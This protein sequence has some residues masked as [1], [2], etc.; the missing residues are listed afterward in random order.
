MKYKIQQQDKSSSY[1]QYIFCNLQ[2][3]QKGPMISLFLNL[4]IL[5]KTW[6]STYPVPLMLVNLLERSSGGAT[7]IRSMLRFLW[8]SPRKSPQC[9]QEY[10][11][12]TW[13]SPYNLWSPRT[14]TSP[15][16]DVLLIMN[17]WPAHL[18]KTSLTKKLLES[19]SSVSW[20]IAK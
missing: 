2:H 1:N 4:A 19:M 11:Y 5:R 12:T 18:T 17:C 20:K 16:G 3:L 9:S 10:V 6:K 8:G 15:C 13:P 14:M 7:E